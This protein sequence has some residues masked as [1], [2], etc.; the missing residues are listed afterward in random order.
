[1]LVFMRMAAMLAVR[2]GD[3]VVDV[4]L[5]LFNHGGVWSAGCSR[6]TIFSTETITY[7]STLEVAAQDKHAYTLDIDTDATAYDNMLCSMVY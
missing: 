5:A 6:V 2:V 3:G 1:M 4:E 7:A